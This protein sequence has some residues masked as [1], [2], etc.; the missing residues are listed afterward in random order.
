M[1]DTKKITTVFVGF[2]LLTTLF[3]GC[4]DRE[5][6]TKVN[7]YHA[8]SLSVPF[9][10]LE[11]KFEDENP[12]IDVR[13]EPAGSVATV[14]KVTDQGKKP[15]VVGV[16]DYSLILKMMYEKDKADWTVRF[17]KNRMVLAYT[18]LSSYKNEISTE[19]WYEILEREAVTY[20][21]SNPNDDP[22]GYRSQMVTLLAENYYGDEYIYDDLVGNHTD[23]EEND[24]NISVP[25]NLGVEN[26]DQITVRSKET[27]LLGILESGNMDYL[28][29]YQSVAEQH[30][31][32]YV[33]LPEQI[34]LSSVEYADNYGK[35]ALIRHTG[36][37]SVGKPIVYGITIPR[38]V[39]NNDGA[40]EFIKFLLGETGREVMSTNGQPTID[41]P[42]VD[43]KQ[44]MPSSLEEMVEKD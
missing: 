21:F 27:D 1:K 41:P 34:D 33:Q 43:N 12:G 42:K 28:F 31:L 14:R 17:A 18:D 44:K 4:L 25:K 6:K 35:V 22:C 9:D 16:A 30:D 7:V 37:R 39:E 24:Y 2:L 38:T 10:E 15:D 3:S 5:D 26:V 32:D 11:K 29:I 8:G 20:G 40:I 23:I 36:D 13:R 19:N